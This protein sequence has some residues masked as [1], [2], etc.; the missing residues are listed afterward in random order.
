MSNTKMVPVMAIGLLKVG[1]KM[2]V[3]YKPNIVFT[4]RIRNIFLDIR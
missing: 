3:L 2:L 1:M 4:N